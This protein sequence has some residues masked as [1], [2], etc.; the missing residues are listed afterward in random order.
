MI[1]KLG[2]QQ[3]KETKEKKKIKMAKASEKS[4]KSD[5]KQI[6]DPHQR[7]ERQSFGSRN[8]S[9]WTRLFPQFRSPTRRPWPASVR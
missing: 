6:R 3:Q 1:C 2:Q 7:D 9:G 5:L 4:V 8:P